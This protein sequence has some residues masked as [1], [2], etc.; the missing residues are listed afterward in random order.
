LAQ[1]HKRED[2]AAKIKQEIDN[3]RHDK[4]HGKK[5]LKR[6]VSSIKAVQRSMQKMLKN[7]LPM[8]IEE[9]K[10]EIIELRKVDKRE[11][12]EFKTKLFA[13][14]HEGRIAH[15]ENVVQKKSRNPCEASYA[16]TN[17]DVYKKGKFS[18][19]LDEA[20]IF[21]QL[22]D[23]E[24]EQLKDK[25][26]AA[27]W[28]IMNKIGEAKKQEEEKVKLQEAWV[29][30]QTKERKA[31]I[32]NM[33]EFVDE[34]LKYKNMEYDRVQKLSVANDL[35]S[36]LEAKSK[37]LHIAVHDQI[38]KNKA[39][40]AEKS[41]RQVELSKLLK[42]L[43]KQID[44]YTNDFQNC[45][46]KII[47]IVPH[48]AKLLH[49]GLF[50]NPDS[51][52]DQLLMATEVDEENVSEI[53]GSI[54]SRIEGLLLGL[55][56]KNKKERRR[57]RRNTQRRQSVS[58]LVGKRKE[59]CTIK[60]K[61]IPAMIDQND[62]ESSR[63]HNPPGRRRSSFYLRHK[64][65]DGADKNKVTEVEFEKN[66]NILNSV[67]DKFAM[68]SNYGDERLIPVE[69]LRTMVKGKFFKHNTSEL[70]VNETGEENGESKEGGKENL[71]ET[72][73]NEKE[74]EH[75]DDTIAPEKK[76]TAEKTQI[77][78]LSKEEYDDNQ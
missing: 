8:T 56:H 27:N 67:F 69:E 42:S 43:D 49:C 6:Y 5:V 50:D 21:D 17:V 37:K 36:N 75:D 35:C 13:V 15:L 60:L 31:K 24:R 12:N 71:N 73:G 53:F 65:G 19:Y 18:K 25:I 77:K 52:P 11:D 7:H 64:I 1:K 33:N 62:V 72:K 63:R 16:P 76:V 30:I 70:L 45:N 28:K 3:I 20:K 58:V 22:S 26:S 2:S 4:V 61:A 66:E 40:L 51:I 29:T 23:A 10:Q 41:I 32:T 46:A 57:Q 38:S 47:K 39:S 34:Y 59:K 74:K 14:R 44:Q 78:E 48:V 54:E 55:E 9:I 68:N